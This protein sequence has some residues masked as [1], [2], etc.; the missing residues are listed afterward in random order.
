M[1]AV[2]LSLPVVGMFAWLVREYW[3]RLFEDE[4][5]DVERRFLAWT[6]KGLAVPMVF[7]I[8]INGGLMPGMPILL[9]EIARAKSRGGDWVRCRQ[10]DT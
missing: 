1:L 3:L 10:P 4:A 7:W 2:L 6:A 9:P 8:I 5:P